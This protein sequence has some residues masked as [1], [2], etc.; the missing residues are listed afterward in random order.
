MNN[1]IDIFTHI[2]KQ[3]GIDEQCTLWW[4]SNRVATKSAKKGKRTCKSQSSKRA[5]NLVPALPALFGLV[6]ELP[7]IF[8]DAPR[9][10]GEG[11][12]KV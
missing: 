7:P 10:N 9:M 4:K 5:S 6:P 3:D 8:L 12:G 11:E 1:L 2:R